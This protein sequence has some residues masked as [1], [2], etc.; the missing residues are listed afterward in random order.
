MRI[1]RIK[2]ARDIQSQLMEPQ[3][4]APP[5]Y[6]RSILTDEQK[7]AAEAKREAMILEITKQVYKTGED[8]EQAV[9][10]KHPNVLY[11]HEVKALPDAQKQALAATIVAW[12]NATENT[13]FLETLDSNRV[14]EY[15]AHNEVFA[16]IVDGEL[17]ACARLHPDIEHQIDGRGRVVFG[18]AMKRP[19][20]FSTTES[21]EAKSA[22]KHVA[23]A[24]LVLCANAYPNLRPRTFISSS[25][26][27]NIEYHLKTLGLDEI[28]PDVP[29]DQKPVNIKLNKLI[30]PL[31]GIAPLPEKVIRAYQYASQSE[32]DPESS[33]G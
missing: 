16:Y 13:G 2:H 29:G 5:P 6:D 9:Y 19:A 22:F 25:N 14:L 23:H 32:P 11:P 17:L 26:R 20:S 12:R 30:D 21:L 27:K 7:T 10:H 18:M 31:K 1:T 8:D 3:P 28:K 4:I 24:R 33:S 15:I